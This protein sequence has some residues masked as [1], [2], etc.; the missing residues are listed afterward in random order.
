MNH[1]MQEILVLPPCSPQSFCSTLIS[2]IAVE[3][4]ILFML[5]WPLT[6][7]LISQT[8]GYKGRSHWPRGLSCRAAAARLLVLRVQ[9]PPGSWLSFYC[10]CCALSGTG[11]CEGADHYSRGVASNV[12]FLNECGP[13]TST[14]RRSW[15]NRTVES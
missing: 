5:D 13:E 1:I 14:M 8:A 3:H 11:L 7:C 4:H 9:I 2:M 6:A 10:E 12:V 15:F